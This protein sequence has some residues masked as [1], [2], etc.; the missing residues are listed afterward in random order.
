ML[1]EGNAKRS[2]G[3]PG[4]PKGHLIKE[5]QEKHKVGVIRDIFFGLAV[6]QFGYVVP[7]TINYLDCDLLAPNGTNAIS[8]Q[9]Q[10]QW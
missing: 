10:R 5:T 4:T 7:L 6:S 3:R 9:H 1:W 2:L 8:G